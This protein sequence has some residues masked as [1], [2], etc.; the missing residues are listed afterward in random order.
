[1]RDT[2]EVSEALAH[3]T[4]KQVELYNE[5]DRQYRAVAQQLAHG[6]HVALEAAYGAHSY[7]ETA[8]KRPPGSIDRRRR[9]LLMTSA[10]NKKKGELLK[11]R[12]ALIPP[13]GPHRVD[14]PTPERLPA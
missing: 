13:C 12:K 4:K 8:V 9:A 7:S 1:L 11:A 5:Y 6:E 10:E 3:Q 2:E 14:S